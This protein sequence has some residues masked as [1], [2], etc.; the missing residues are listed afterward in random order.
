MDES[1]TGSANLWSASVSVQIEA[2]ASPHDLAAVADVLERVEGRRVGVDEL[3][4]DLET[5]PD[6][7]FF[8]ARID[9]EPVG[10]AVGKRS[11]Q[12]GTLFAMARV[13]PEARRRGTGSAL[14]ASLSDHAALLG[15]AQLW[16]RV[17]EPEAL[18]FVRNRGFREFGREIESV[19][20][21]TSLREV[22]PPPGI[23][24]TN[25]GE[26]PE[27]AEAC[28]AIDSE[29]VPDI[30]AGAQF[31]AGPFERWRAANLDGPASLPHA[32][33]VALAAGVEVVGY[34]A[35]LARTAEP[36]TAEH[37]LTAVKRAWRR[38]G[39]AA[40]LKR[41]QIAWAAE[42]GFDRLVTYNDEANAPMRGVNARLGYEPQPPTVL[43]LGP[44]AL[45]A[46]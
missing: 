13:V 45:P 29:A 8:I 16:G 40:A 5:E 23:E 11:S 25:L 19:L 10:S 14:Y 17:R 28:H 26:R 46:G 9:G 32:C 4:H 43:V 3:R 18:E 34:A 24:I 1:A 27:L 21:V 31:A 20:I 42:N 33:T 38:R 35:L 44:L 39:I 41:A 2:A 7:R 6:T 36:G 22:A 12:A 30:P 37:Q 15:L